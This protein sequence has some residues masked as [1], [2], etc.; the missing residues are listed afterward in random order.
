MKNKI[1]IL[2]TI[3]VILIIIGLVWFGMKGNYQNNESPNSI[4]PSNNESSE[5]IGKYVCLPH[6][7]SSGPQ[8]LECAFGLLTQEGNYYALNT[9]NINQDEIMQLNTDEPIQ[10]I[11]TFISVNSLDPHNAL[12]KYDIVGVINAT[13]ITNSQESNSHTIAGGDLTFSVPKDFGLAVS[14][15]QMPHN[16]TIPPCSEGFE[17]C[18]YYNG[19]QYKNTN[20]E[21][22]GISIKKRTDLSTKVSCMNTNP[23]GYTSL[24]PI[25]VNKDSYSVST[26]AP[27]QDAG[28]GH[29]AD[30]NLDRLFY[31]NSCYE[32]ETRTAQTAYGN[33]PSGTIQ[34]FTPADETIMKNRLLSIVQNMRITDKKNEI[35]FNKM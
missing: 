15:D 20:F 21:T 17:Y 16:S 11:G 6:K 31:K 25:I 29:S 14:S 10:V 3:I 2:S 22:A 32:V 13:S 30:G 33:Y 18:I 4:P 35:I 9:S 23:D 12:T 19:D 26:F 1:A 28:A 34:E 5:Y 7:D 8:T 27:I 24:K